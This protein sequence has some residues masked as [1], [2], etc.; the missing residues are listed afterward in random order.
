MIE[1]DMITKLMT[2]SWMARLFRV[3]PYENTKIISLK[4][5]VN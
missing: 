2:S 5:Y 1:E 3:E 4:K